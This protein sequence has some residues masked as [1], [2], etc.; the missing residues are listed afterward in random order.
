[1][2][3]SGH[4]SIQRCESGTSCAPVLRSYSFKMVSIATRVV[5]L[6]SSGAR[7]ILKWSIKC[8]Q[9]ICARDLAHSS[10]H[11]FRHWEWWT[12]TL[13]WKSR[14]LMHCGCWEIR[15][16]MICA[17]KTDEIMEHFEKSIFTSV[18]Q[19]LRRQPPSHSE[20]QGPCN[21]RDFVSFHW[22]WINRTAFKFIAFYVC[23][24][25]HEM[26][27]VPQQIIETTLFGCG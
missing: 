21:K 14:T 3:W 22:R 2:R 24:S 12:L 9:K 7:I 15:K 20:S 18:G 8:W 10:G 13:F 4:P 23:V 1:M 6:E 27:K 26:L 16:W 5:T 19:V 17:V 11:I 25:V